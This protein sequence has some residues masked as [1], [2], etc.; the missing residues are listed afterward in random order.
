[1]TF[2]KFELT[3]FNDAW[4]QMHEKNVQHRLSAFKEL[5]KTALNNEGWFEWELYY[6]LLRVDRGWKRE[7]KNRK[8]D[9]RRYGDGV[10]L[11]FSNGH[12]IELRAITTER[13][14][15][16]WVLE[17]LLKHPDADAVIFLA[18]YNKNLRRWLE[19]HKINGNN[20]HMQIHH[21]CT[22][23]KIYHHG[24]FEIILRHINEDW[25]IGMVKRTVS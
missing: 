16:S 10:D 7:K 2:N 23:N 8:G 1:M 5:R 18:L 9:N 14:T 4:E 15:M 13:S 21:S 3:I 24:D 22:I 17:G 20:T 25:V 12:F 19:K 11:Q 6:R